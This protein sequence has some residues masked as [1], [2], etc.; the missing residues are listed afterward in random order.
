M[1]NYITPPV[2][3]DSAQSSKGA[4]AHGKTASAKG[5]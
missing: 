4:T 5:R 1:K 2:E 3:L